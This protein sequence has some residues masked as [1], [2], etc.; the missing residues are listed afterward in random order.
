MTSVPDNSVTGCTVSWGSHRF[1]VMSMSFGCVLLPDLLQMSKWTNG[2]CLHTLQSQSHWAFAQFIPEL[3]CCT[4][5][6]CD[7]IKKLL[8][9]P[10]SQSAYFRS[11]YEHGKREYADFKVTAKRHFLSFT[12]CTLSGEDMVVYLK[13]PYPNL[14]LSCWVLHV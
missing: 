12:V 11:V 8:R 5:S 10:T 6:F 3:V 2:K 4:C 13:G 9:N 1:I 7:A 14:M